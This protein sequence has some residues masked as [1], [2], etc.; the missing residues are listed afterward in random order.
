MGTVER[1]F[2][3]PI[4]VGDT[5][6]P[7]RTRDA[8]MAIIPGDGKRLLSGDDERIDAYSGLA[9][10]WRQAEQIWN[11]HRSSELTLLNRIDYQRGLSNQVPAGPYRI[12]YSKSGMYIAA[13]R[14]S[15]LNAIIDHSLYWAEAGSVEEA[16]YLTAILNSDTLLEVIRPLQSR[17]EHNP[18]HFD[19]YIFKAPIPLFDTDNEAHQKLVELAAHAEEAAASVEL[20]DGRS[21]QA[22]R[23]HIRQTL[24][25]EGVASGIDDVVRAL[26]SMHEV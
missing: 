21:F 24:E 4:Y 3:H 13:A 19:K 9:E 26:L 8:S 2:V 18:R 14:V 20:P 5:V 10:W 1:Q 15:D 11:Q 25:S 16:R 17:G 7:F 23:R 12:V 6:L 22:L